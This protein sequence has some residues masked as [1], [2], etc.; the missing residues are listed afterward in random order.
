MDGQL[1]G[2]GPSECMQ[3]NSLKN[4]GSSPSF[5]TFALVILRWLLTNGHSD[6]HSICLSGDLSDVELKIL[7]DYGLMTR[8]PNAFAAWNERNRR[9]DLSREADMKARVKEGKA[10]LIGQEVSK[11]QAIF[12]HY[13]INKAV[14]FFP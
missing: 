5:R 8:C 13:A 3:C 1:G 2:T 10:N 6:A 11:L 7:G 4:C 14:G 12:L 9:N